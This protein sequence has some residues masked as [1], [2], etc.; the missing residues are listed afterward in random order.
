M[1]ITKV[2]ETE[3]G[4]R[5][6]NYDGKCSHLHGHSY[7]WEV[8]VWAETLDER[9]MVADFKELK[10]AMKEVIEPL[11][12]AM[13]LNER[14]PALHVLTAMAA[15]NGQ[16][17]RVLGVPF[18][19]TAEHF[20]AWSARRIQAELPAGVFVVRVRVWETSNSHATWE[21]EDVR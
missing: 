16:T 18:N 8:T 2:M 5:L 11:D 1:Y 15:T 7:R 20:A 14:D 12:H 17:Q 3:T 9:G 13:V 10:E 19:P 4:H 21:D 6:L